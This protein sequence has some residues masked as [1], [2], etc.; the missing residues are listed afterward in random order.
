MLPL[1]TFLKHFSIIT[2]LDFNVT[3][4]KLYIFVTTIL[5]I[6]NNYIIFIILFLY[7]K[8]IVINVDYLYIC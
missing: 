2:F 3:L 1:S 4:F 8:K 7:K 6:L 5:C